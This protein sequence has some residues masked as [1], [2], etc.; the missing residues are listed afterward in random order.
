[1]VREQSEEEHA[2]SAGD[3]RCHVDYSISVIFEL[4]TAVGPAI[5]ASAS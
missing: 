2:R 4:Y 5:R 1:M 3:I